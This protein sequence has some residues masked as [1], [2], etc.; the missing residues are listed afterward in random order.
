[1]NLKSVLAE[2]LNIKI[3]AEENTR[4]ARNVVQ[5]IVALVVS[6]L[7]V[8]ALNRG[9][10]IEALTGVTPASL[11]LIISPAAFGLVSRGVVIVTEAI[12]DRWPTLARLIGLLNGP[13]SAPKYP[14]PEVVN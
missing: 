13:K 2:F 6:Q 11:V 4:T 12:R 10:D 1:M 14:D 9:F 3:N 5:A 8:W 7:F